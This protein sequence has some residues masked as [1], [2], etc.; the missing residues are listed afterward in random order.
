MYRKD[1]IELEYA[2]YCLTLIQAVLGSLQFQFLLFSKIQS[3]MAR[4]L[5]HKM[6][7]LFLGQ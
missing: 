6:R 5:E 1:A 7:H 2:F 4:N 3:E